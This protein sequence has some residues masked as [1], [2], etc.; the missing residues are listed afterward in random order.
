MALHQA[1]SAGGLAR[2][3]RGAAP[4]L[5]MSGA[6]T[7]K[8]AIVT[9]GSGAIG[10]A[11]ARHLL[12]DGAAVLLMGRRADA[13]EETRRSLLQH[14]PDGDVACFAGD[15]CVE[16]DV[17][18]AFDAA[19]ALR[20]RLDIVVATVGGGHGFKPLLMLDAE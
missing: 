10:A 11:S 9:G 8:T 2:D 20:G 1:A 17:Q 12:Q 3:R 7:G 15:A 19:Y 16:S 13:L 5:I 4:G 6:L 18:A 14:V